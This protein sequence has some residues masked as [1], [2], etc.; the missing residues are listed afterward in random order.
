M[1]LIR[2]N[3]SSS[4][5]AALGNALFFGI[6]HLFQPHVDINEIL[7]DKSKI[8][9]AKSKVKVISEVRQLEGKTQAI[10]VGVDSKIGEKTLDYFN[11]AFMYLITATKLLWPNSLAEKCVLRLHPKGPTPKHTIQFCN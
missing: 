5:G 1:E 7:I 11:L 6:K 8:D 4:L 10:C 2:G 3:L 9:R